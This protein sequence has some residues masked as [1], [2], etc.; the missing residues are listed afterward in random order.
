MFF[1][2]QEGCQRAV[3]PSVRGSGGYEPYK[4][5]PLYIRERSVI[6]MDILQT[7][8]ARRWTL[9]S[10]M[11][12][13]PMAWLISVDGSTIDARH[14]PATSRKLPIARD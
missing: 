13:N 2:L 14:A 3:F 7:L 10:L 4:G 12:R 1:L 9:P 6:S 11:D 8:L 5:D